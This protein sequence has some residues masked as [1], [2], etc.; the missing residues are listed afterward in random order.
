MMKITPEYFSPTEFIEKLTNIGG[1]RNQRIADTLT[2]ALTI[3][4]LISINHPATDE[5]TVRISDSSTLS[6]ESNPYSLII[7]TGM[8]E[9]CI[10]APCMPVEKIC[11]AMTST[12]FNYNSLASI[13]LAWIIAH[14]YFH[15]VR[16]HN[17]VAAAA[18]KLPNRPYENSIDNALE[19]DADL[20]A[21]SVI[22]RL[23][24]M[25]LGSQIH[26]LD[27]RRITIYSLFFTLR[28]FPQNQAD[29]AHS[30]MPERLYHIYFKLIQMIKGPE[31]E[32]SS[33]VTEYSRERF[34]PLALAF[35]QCDD[36]FQILTKTQDSPILKIFEEFG[37]N[38]RTL[39]VVESWHWISS[40]VEKI[41]KRPTKQHLKTS[42]IDTCI[43]CGRNQTISIPVIAPWISKKL[44]ITRREQTSTNIKFQI[45]PANRN[46]NVSFTAPYV[47]ETS[48]G[49]EQIDRMCKVCKKEW[50][51]PLDIETMSFLAP[52]LDGTKLTVSDDEAKLISLYTCIIAALFDYTDPDPKNRLIPAAYKRNLRKNKVPR[53][54]T[55]AIRPLEKNSNYGIRS[56]YFSSNNR[57]NCTICNIHLGCIFVQ[58]VC[59][60]DLE[61]PLYFDQS[62]YLVIHPTKNSSTVEHI[63]ALPISNLNE[64]SSH[65]HRAMI[66]W[67]IKNNSKLN[68]KRKH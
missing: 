36:Y 47:R 25:Q 17:D 27:V 7:S 51:D 63:H 38:T 20:M 49:D 48:L 26:D 44:N 28:T 29:H 8:I 13:S 22:Y 10:A 60:I 1:Y 19:H 30:A 3:I 57:P 53:N 54:W 65:L 41:C 66:M 56:Q 64:E 11:T 62:K 61:Y 35:K 21:V 45:P 58:L 16:R 4:P 12:N 67:A 18:S 9:H 5:I 23:I 31:E 14:E 39:E 40:T 6:A 37:D 43:F 15:I 2:D 68:N 32:F 34:T 33:S 55:V 24:Q 59:L 52:L 50:F 46:S 42:E